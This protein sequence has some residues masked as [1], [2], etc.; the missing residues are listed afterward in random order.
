MIL[1]ILIS[2]VALFGYWIG[3]NILNQ[4]SVEQALLISAILRSLLFLTAISFLK[5]DQSTISGSSP[6]LIFWKKMVVIAWILGALLFYFVNETESSF[7]ILAWF[8]YM[9]IWFREQ[10][11][12]YSLFIRIVTWFV[13]MAYAGLIPVGLYAIYS[14]YSEEEFFYVL[15]VVILA[16][17]WF[18]S[19][20]SIEWIVGFKKPSNNQKSKPVLLWASILIMVGFCFV[21]FLNYQSHFYPS[22]QAVLYPGIT[23]STPFLCQPSEPDPEVY[24]GNQIFKDYLEL[25][26]DNPAKATPEFG[27]LALGMSNL[28]YARLFKENLIRD[29]EAEN[30][31]QPS[32]SVK[33]GQYEAAL[34]IYYYAKLLDTFPSLFS[35]VEKTNLQS[36]FA[37]I[38]RRT[39]TVEWV[40][41]LYSAAFRIFPRGPYENQEIGSGLLA[42]IE[43]YKLSTGDLSEE[44][45][46]YLDSNVRGWNLRFRNT[47]DAIMYQPIW[48]NN[49]YFQYLFTGIANKE[50]LRLS[51]EWILDQ[52]PVNGAA[53]QYNHPEA[54]QLAG[55][56]YLGAG[57]L[58]DKHLLWLAGKEVEYA[59]SAGEHLFAQPGMEKP[60]ELTGTSPVVGSCL[61]YSHHGLPN[62]LGP[63][64]PD[65]LILREGWTDDSA[66]I[67]INL[68]SSGWH[69]YKSTGSIISYQHSSP[70]VVEP[71]EGGRITWLP[72][73][74]SHFRDKRIPKENLNTVVFPRSGLSAVLYHVTGIGSSWEQFVP[75]EAIVESFKGDNFTFEA[76]ISLS[77]WHGWTI[78]RK[79]ILSDGILVVV[80][81]VDDP[82]L[83]EARLY[84]HVNGNVS[85]DEIFVLDDNNSVSERIKFL[86]FENS[87]DK[88]V[89]KTDSS[90]RMA[91]VEIPFEGKKGSMISLF[92]SGN[93]LGSSVKIDKSAKGGSL[94]LQS[95]YQ[96]MEIPL[97]V[98]LEDKP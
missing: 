7:W 68:R 84:W 43:T 86:S 80:D 64:G 92:L 27:M 81:T 40:D 17:L 4:K 57:L 29:A 12:P 55:V 91:V 5:K 88:P 62:Q 11:Q 78:K 60:I 46:K 94:I 83:Q 39:L 54:T 35:E 87:N 61:L 13:A 42:L 10:L 95:Q 82:P 25:V 69:R 6:R 34:R 66:Y 56:S 73:G 63:L 8:F 26:L 75:Q 67:L 21:L 51:F 15:Q 97:G 48:L 20:L 41:W 96:T 65:K 3:I 52:A 19:A 74:R 31:T 37:K 58:Q 30:Y 71:K 59:R 72:Y 47:D 44:N 9:M 33:F 28:E 49:A 45:R 2:G 32:N 1:R 22:R 89:I 50:N 38:N 77:D 24:D 70:I 98:Y 18:I 90:T 16:L 23:S 76:Q 85:G 79:F 93:W 14:H 36:W 53:L